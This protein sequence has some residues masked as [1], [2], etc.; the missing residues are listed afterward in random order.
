MESLTKIKA[1]NDYA[2]SFAGNKV[3]GDN[4]IDSL[5]LVKGNL[6]SLRTNIQTDANLSAEE[7]TAYTAEINSELSRLA[8]RINNELL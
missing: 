3:L 4:N 5:I 2:D 8:G 6:F 1:Q 7:K